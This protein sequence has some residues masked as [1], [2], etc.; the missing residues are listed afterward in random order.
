MELLTTTP[1]TNAPSAGLKPS[2][3]AITATTTQRATT[4]TVKSSRLRVLATAASSWGTPYRLSVIIATQKIEALPNAKTRAPAPPSSSS[5]K[6]GSRTMKKMTARS[7]KSAMPS[8][9]R[10]G[11]LSGAP[12]SWKHF[13]DTAVDERANANPAT[14]AWFRSKPQ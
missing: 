14:I 5:S 9:T 6:T 11:G 3:P 12:I 1:A 10:P 8:A 13:I 4:A 2:K 7:W